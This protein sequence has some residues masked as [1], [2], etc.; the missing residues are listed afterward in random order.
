MNIKVNR[1][2]AVPIRLM[3]IDGYNIPYNINSTL[4][5]ERFYKKFLHLK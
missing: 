2:I 5:K 3:L 1:S 4:N